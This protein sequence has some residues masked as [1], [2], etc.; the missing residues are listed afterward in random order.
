MAIVIIDNR[1]P[2]TNN[3]I[4]PN[5]KLTDIPVGTTFEAKCRMRPDQKMIFIRT[6]RNI[7]CLNSPNM[8]WKVVGDGIVSGVFTKD[9]PIVKV[10]VKLVLYVPQRYVVKKGK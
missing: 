1:K 8:T 5:S 7:S 3:I 4:D 2:A 6:P 9:F 10:N